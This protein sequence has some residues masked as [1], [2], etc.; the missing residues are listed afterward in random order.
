MAPRPNTRARAGPTPS[1]PTAVAPGCRFL[2]SP[3]ALADNLGGGLVVAHPKEA[4]LPEPT[5]TRPLGEADLGNQLGAS[6]VRAARDRSRIGERRLRRLQLPQPHPKL[7]ERRCGVTGTDLPGVFELASLV[8]AD[9]EGA[10]VGETGRTIL[11]RHDGRTP[12]VCLL[13]HGLT[14]SPPQFAEFGRLLYERGM[15]QI[16]RGNCKRAREQL[17]EALA[18]FQRLGARHSVKQSEQA[19]ATL[20]QN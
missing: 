13:L 12:R 7:A 19:L 17:E 8:V 11:L 5:L 2:C 9:E 15:A 3:G 1:W 4:R 6:P 14:A 20:R 18:I 10:E 16:Q